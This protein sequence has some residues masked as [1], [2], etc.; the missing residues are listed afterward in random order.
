MDLRNVFTTY[1][2]LSD[3]L[4]NVRVDQLLAKDS[5]SPLELGSSE[6]PTYNQTVLMPEFTG[7]LDALEKEQSR[8]G[9]LSCSRN[10]MASALQSYLSAK[11]I[12]TG[13]LKPIDGA[14]GDVFEVKFDSG[15]VTG[16][17]R[18]FLTWWGGLK[19]HAWISGEADPVVL[20]NKLRVALLS[21]WGTGLYGAPISMQT[22]ASDRSGYDLIMHL[23]DVYYS[24]TPSEQRERLLKFWPLESRAIQRALNAN[25]DMYT[26]G[27]GYFDVALPALA[28]KSSYFAFVNDFWLLVALDTAYQEHDLANEQASWLQH[29]IGKYAGRKLIL[30]SHH[31]PFSLLDSQG[32]RL[33]ARLGQ[34]LEAKLIHAWY[35]G[36]EHRCV[37]Y[38]GHPLWGFNGRCLGHGGYPYFRHDLANLPFLSGS[39]AWRRFESKN[40]VPGA[41]FLDGP[42]PYVD[43][44]ESEYGPNGYMTLEFDNETLIEAVYLPDGSELWKRPVS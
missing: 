23:G 14:P 6:S 4:R 31:Q 41:L 35:W 33:V 32:P 27:Y 28:Q 3:S 5:R 20:Q 37:L 44:Y 19:P 29:L 18:S 15:D 17:L 38:D 8:P 36:H 13:N 43:G 10:P 24:G 34:L 22:I 25:H 26:G 39:T 9:I 7:A 21:D 42:N 2:A 16:W 40:F 30:F 11:G 12:E 1:E